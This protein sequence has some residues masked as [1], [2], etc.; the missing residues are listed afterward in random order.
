M[1]K[2]NLRMDHF[3]V[4]EDGKQYFL[5]AIDELD[6]WK[7]KHNDLTK[8]KK[9]DVTKKLRKLMN[10]HNIYAN[11]NFLINMNND[12]EEVKIVDL[13]GGG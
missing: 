12:E 8:L 7:K 11:V 6:E 1:K 10:H 5:T 3:F 4:I 13:E 9:K 2:T